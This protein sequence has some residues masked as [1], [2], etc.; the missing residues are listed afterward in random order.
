MKGDRGTPGPFV[1]PGSHWTFVFSVRFPSPIPNSSPFLPSLLA[2]KR[3]T[4][5]TPPAK[6]T[7]QEP[8]TGNVCSEWSRS[9]ESVQEIGR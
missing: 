4:A 3:Q 7:G 9:C 5:P 8:F 1:L 6:E 2:G